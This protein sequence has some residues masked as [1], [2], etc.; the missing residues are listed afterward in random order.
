MPPAPPDLLDAR[1]H[2]LLHSLSTAHL[3]ALVVT[4]LPNV[5]YLT[6]FVGS[7]AMALVTRDGLRLITDGRYATIAERR[8]A[9]YRTVTTTTVAS[10][11]SYEETLIDT[12]RPFAGGRVALEEAH[13]SLQRFRIFEAARE[14][15]AMPDLIPTDGLVET[16]RA[17]KDSWE[18]ATLREAAGRLSECAA[19]ILPKPL[20]GRTEREVAFGIEKEIRGRGFERLAFETIVAAGPNAALPHHR[21]TE[22]RIEE[23]ELVVLDFGGVFRGYSVDMAR[24]V[25]AG[26]A[27]ARERAV[28]DAVARAQAAAFE[29]VCPGAQP[30]EVDAAA[31]AAL[32]QVQMDHAFTHATGHGLGLEVHERPRIGPPRAHGLEPPLAASM[33][34]TLEPGAYFPAWGGARLEDDVLVTTSGAE[35]LTGVPAGD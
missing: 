6:G 27:G 19:R 18:V 2:R 33:V 26:L 17:E 8:A 28:L 22:R 12:I 4:S 13:L 1:F 24:T 21:P 30:E 10:G 3:D 31:R 11:S 5:A 9:D 14:T 7:A 16:L 23:G 20:A 34:L 15:G 29:K 32:A 35:R 25:T